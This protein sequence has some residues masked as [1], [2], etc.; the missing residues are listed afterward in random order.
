MNKVTIIQDD[1]NDSWAEV[2]LFRWQYGTLP[3][4]D[5]T[6]PLDIPK[7]L[8]GM[9]AAIEAGNESNFPSPFNVASVLKFS[10]KKIREGNR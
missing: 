10:A 8:E 5:D 2:E 4:S 3:A 7:G 1:P 6:R 9:A